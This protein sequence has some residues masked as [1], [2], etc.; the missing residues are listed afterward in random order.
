MPLYAVRA[1]WRPGIYNTW[2]EAQLQIKGF[3]SAQFHKFS[4]M[5]DAVGYMSLAHLPRNELLTITVTGEGTCLHS[6]SKGRL[7]CVPS[8]SSMYLSE[9]AVIEKFM[10]AVADA[11][12]DRHAFDPLCVRVMVNTPSITKLNKPSA[13]FHTGPLARLARCRNTLPASVSIVFVMSSQAESMLKA[14]QPPQ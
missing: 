8:A 13:V 14:K 2:Q 10:L 6:P 9:V 11:H 7:M 12:S 5:E 3:G 4:H 1:G